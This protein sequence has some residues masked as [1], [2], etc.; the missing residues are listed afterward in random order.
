MFTFFSLLMTIS[1]VN[2]NFEGNH[3]YNFHNPRIMQKTKPHNPREKLRACL[4]L[5]ATMSHTSSGEKRET[6]R[7]TCDV[8]SPQDIWPEEKDLYTEGIS[9]AL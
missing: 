5:K 2:S 7:V 1:H 8:T 9:N 4:C 3:R 6:M